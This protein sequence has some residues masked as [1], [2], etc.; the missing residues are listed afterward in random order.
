MK[1]EVNSLD[2]HKNVVVIGVLK[3]K[4]S[5]KSSWSSF[6]KL[7][8]SYNPKSEFHQLAK[9]L[10]ECEINE[11][12]PLNSK[13]FS[14]TALFL[15]NRGLF[16]VG[17]IFYYDSDLQ[18]IY[19]SNGI[20]NQPLS[21]LGQIW[22]STHIVNPKNCG[23]IYA[24]SA[25]I[26]PLI[27]LYFHLKNPILYISSIYLS[28]LMVVGYYACAIII[29]KFIEKLI[30]ERIITFSDIAGS[31]YKQFALYIKYF[32]KKELNEFIKI[33]DK[34]YEES[35]QFQKTKYNGRNDT[36]E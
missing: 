2:S 30:G 10:L 8:Y 35:S 9:D 23:I 22:R 1:I 25:A 16:Q 19:V 12:H 34:L 32:D 31:N 5:K 20:M 21:F 33:I 4:Y 27:L 6:K 13:D 17:R 26:L 18:T 24:A 36:D 29:W 28:L 7:I 11:P 14:D 15:T 3:P